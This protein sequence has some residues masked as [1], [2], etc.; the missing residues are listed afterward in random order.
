MGKAK[1][2]F[3]CSFETDVKIDSDKLSNFVSDVGD[4][5]A[6]TFFDD[7]TGCISVDGTSAFLTSNFHKNK[8]YVGK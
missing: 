3:T 5:A 6:E 8:N 7:I 1:Y 4:L 2:V